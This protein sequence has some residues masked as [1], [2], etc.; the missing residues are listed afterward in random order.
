MSVLK[1]P[2]NMVIMKNLHIISQSGQYLTQQE[3]AVLATLR[4]G[5]NFFDNSKISDNPNFPT[6]PNVW[7]MHNFV[8]T[9]ISFD[10][11][12]FF[13]NSQYSYNLDCSDNSDSSVDQQHF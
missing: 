1:N 5:S 7:S 9:F 4:L 12:E 6:I 10:D 8:D 13:I 2:N 3:E 11:V